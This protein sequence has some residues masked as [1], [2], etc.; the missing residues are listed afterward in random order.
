MHFD[1]MKSLRKLFYQV[2]IFAGNRLRKGSTRFMKLLD[3]LKNDPAV[4]C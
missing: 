3:W 2:R 1:A 4:P